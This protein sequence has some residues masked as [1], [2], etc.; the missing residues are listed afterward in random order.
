MKSYYY[1]YLR[2]AG[3]VAKVIYSGQVEDAFGPIMGPGDDL[4]SETGAID[5]GAC[6]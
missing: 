1:P 3:E 2:L 4:A 5:G 6:K